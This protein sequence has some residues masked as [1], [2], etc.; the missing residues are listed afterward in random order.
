[1]TED[2]L[3]SHLKIDESQIESDLEK[4]DDE[5]VDVDV[6]HVKQ[7][8]TEKGWTKLECICM[9]TDLKEQVGRKYVRN[10][11][12]VRAGRGA[13]VGYLRRLSRT[14]PLT[15]SLSYKFG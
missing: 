8:F 2:V 7:F 9:D 11:C 3:I 6:Y 4:I 5:V 15:P 13:G 12:A 14:R 10:D 1:M